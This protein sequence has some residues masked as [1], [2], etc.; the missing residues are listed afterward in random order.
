MFKLK[1][2]SNADLLLYS[3]SH[4]E[5]DSR[6]LHM[7][8]QWCLP[9]TLTSTGNSSSRM[10]IPVFSP[11]LPG[12]IDV[13]QTIP[14]ML[15][16]AGPFLDRPHILH[17]LRDA[18]HFSEVWCGK[19]GRARDCRCLKASDLWPLEPWEPHWRPW[20]AS[21]WERHGSDS[22]PLR[23][24]HPLLHGPVNS[25]A[26]HPRLRVSKLFWQGARQELFEALWVMQVLLWVQ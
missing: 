20:A 3:L 25:L 6:T 17:L 26:S 10:R 24:C 5:C 11:W 22:G 12:Y 8:T 2:K 1:A 16:M 19:V 9:P 21:G 18:V 13:V 15:T 4:F 7:L 23:R 14:I